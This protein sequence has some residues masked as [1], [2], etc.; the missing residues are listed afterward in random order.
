MSRRSR[1]VRQREIRQRRNR[2]EKLKKLREKYLSAKTPEEK[3]KI[4]EK[5]AKIAP[6]LSEEEFLKAKK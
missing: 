1:N 2:K 3:A 6:W 5:V 4:L